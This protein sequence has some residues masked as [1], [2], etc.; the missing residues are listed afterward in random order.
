[1]VSWNPFRRGT[2]PSRE[3]GRPE[4]QEDGQPAQPVDWGYYIAITLAFIGIAAVAAVTMYVSYEA[5]HAFTTDIKGDHE[6]QKQ[7]NE[8]G[9]AAWDIAAA[10]FAILGLA[11]AMRGDN[12]LR[13]RVGNIACALASVAMNG[14]Q[15]SAPENAEPHVLAGHLLVWLG[16]PLLYA[17]TTDM[18]IMEIQRRSMERRGLP[19]ENASLWSVVGVLVKAV[20]GVVLW[21]GRLVLDPF[22]TI[23]MFREWY[24]GEVAY[25]PN[26]TVESDKARKALE[27]ASAA[28]GFAEEV[29]RKSS[30]AIA[31][32]QADYTR[33]A[34][35]AEQ[36]AQDAIREARAAEKTRADEAIRKERERATDAIAKADARVEELEAAHALALQRLQEDHTAALQRLGQE[37]TRAIRALEDTVSG[38]RQEVERLRPALQEAQASAARG[39]EHARALEDTRGQLDREQQARTRVEQQA[40]ALRTETDDLFARLSGNSQVQYL[41]DRL[42]RLGDPRHGNPDYLSEI[43]QEF[44]ERHGVSLTLAK[45]M[46][47]IRIHLSETGPAASGVTGGSDDSMGGAQ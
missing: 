21:F 27:A 9:A 47:Y 19:L 41:Y 45:I 13:A 4:D 43:A 24:L 23:K 22:Q 8:L 26:R 12:A 42:G 25:A 2:S 39:A 31:E 15:I 32:A 14:A 1:M 16:P 33:R 5:Q 44:Q 40:R 34:N 37:H 7:A 20:V 11:T 6:S 38:Q 3:I 35:E 28:K 46:H 17:A 30:S 29:E 10:A 36:A 18:I